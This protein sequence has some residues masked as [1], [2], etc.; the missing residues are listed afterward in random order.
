[1]DPELENL[2]KEYFPQEVVAE[3]PEVF[4]E[5]PDCCSIEDLIKDIEDDSRVNPLIESRVPTVQIKYQDAITYMPVEE[6]V[7]QSIVLDVIHRLHQRGP[8][9]FLNL[10]PF[11]GEGIYAV[12]YQG[13]LPLYEPFRSIGSTCPIYFGKASNEGTEQ[14]L[15]TRLSDHKRT[16]QRSNI[17]LA[18]LTFRFVCLPVTLVEF[19]ERNLI[20][21][22]KPLW[23]EYLTGFGG[24]K[25]TRASTQYQTQESMWSAYHFIQKPNYRPREIEAIEEGMREFSHISRA[26]YTE[27][28]TLLENHHAH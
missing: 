13:D 22:F 26:A 23:N 14:S 15:F 17:S 2:L 25:R 7:I 4:A 27:V 6:S 20:T 9:T 18:D 21:L 24:G 28:M 8:F 12:Y 10:T 19:A 16:L 3:E 11:D 5:G 1:M